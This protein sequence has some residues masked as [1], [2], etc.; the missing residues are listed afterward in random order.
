[1]PDDV[2]TAQPKSQPAQAATNDWAASYAAL[3]EG[4]QL[5]FARWM[6][7]TMA[8]SQEITRF[9]Q[10]RLQEDVAAWWNVVA[11][12]GPEEAMTCQRRFAT[13]ASEQYAE[14]MSR[15]SQMMMNAAGEGLSWLRQRQDIAA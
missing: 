10:S 6:Q 15:L 12:H 3:L 2:K 14:E 11:C 1:M 5:A 7:S 13:E 9:A 8:I 4:N